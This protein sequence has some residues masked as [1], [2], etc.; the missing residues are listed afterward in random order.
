MVVADDGQNMVKGS[1]R[2][3]NSLADDSVL[4]HDFSFFVRQRSGLEQDVLRYSQLADIVNEAASAQG[5]PQRLG[6][7]KLFASAT[8]YFEG[9]HSALRCKDPSLR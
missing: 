1:E 7:A 8:E 6:Q 9:G 2:R 4:L 3:A 5:E